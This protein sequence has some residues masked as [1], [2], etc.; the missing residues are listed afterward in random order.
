[1]VVEYAM[2]Y[3]AQ[4]IYSH[5]CFNS[6]IINNFVSMVYPTFAKYS[7]TTSV[8]TFMDL[9]IFGMYESIHLK[10]YVDYFEQIIHFRRKKELQ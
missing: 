3:T 7:K 2:H 4:G 10:S 5:E 9:P 1:M 8:P 6:I